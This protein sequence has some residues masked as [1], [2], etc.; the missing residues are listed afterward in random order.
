M[1]VVLYSYSMH[2]RAESQDIQTFSYLEKLCS[3]ET[4]KYSV[5]HLKTTSMCCYYQLLSDVTFE[6]ARSLISLRKDLEVLHN[7]WHHQ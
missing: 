5:V 7:I 6:V 4:N 2:N 3:E 1:P